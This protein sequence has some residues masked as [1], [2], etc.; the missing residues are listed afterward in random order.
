MDWV[1]FISR[2]SNKG[3]SIGIRNRIMNSLIKIKEQVNENED[4][5]E[6]DL[7]VSHLQDIETGDSSQTD[8]INQRIL[9]LYFKSSNL[10]AI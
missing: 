8:M 10:Y 6:E 5:T 3:V 4:W 9:N 2:S 1:Y 7:N